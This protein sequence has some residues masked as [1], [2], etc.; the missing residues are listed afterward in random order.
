MISIYDDDETYKYIGGKIHVDLFDALVK[1][2]KAT[3]RTRTQLMREAIA[4]LIDEHRIAGK[5]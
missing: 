1:L 5:L 4:N 2:A 3:G